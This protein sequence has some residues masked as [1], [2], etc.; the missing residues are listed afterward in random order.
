MVATIVATI[1]PEIKKKNYKKKNENQKNKT[2]HS[3]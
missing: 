1:N 3:Y 2:W